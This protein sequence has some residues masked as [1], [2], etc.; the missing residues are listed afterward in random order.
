MVSNPSVYRYE[1]TN[2]FSRY[3]H[4]VGL[5]FEDK[6]LRNSDTYSAQQMMQPYH[7]REVEWLEGFLTACEFMAEM[8]V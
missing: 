2:W 6:F 3:P 4:L 1:E 7:Q 8:D 5:Y